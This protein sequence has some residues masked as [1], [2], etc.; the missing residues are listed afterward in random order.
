[1]YTVMIGGGIS[2]CHDYLTRTTPSAAINAWFKGILKCPLDVGIEGMGDDW[3]SDLYRET[4]SGEVVDLVAYRAFWQYIYDNPQKVRE[5]EG[6]VCRHKKFPYIWE[7]IA[8]EAIDKAKK[9]VNAT[10]EELIKEHGY[11]GY[12]P[13]TRG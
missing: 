5:A 6:K 7:C 4:G 9:L 1:M 12:G 2:E 3:D 11:S 8:P 13:F 10:D